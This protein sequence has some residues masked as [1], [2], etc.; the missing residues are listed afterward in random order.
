[1]MVHGTLITALNSQS[2][3]DH[4][5][6]D[7]RFRPLMENAKKL[8]LRS[9]QNRVLYVM[10]PGHY[11]IIVECCVM[12]NSCEGSDVD[13]DHP[14]PFNIFPIIFKTRLCALMVV[15][16][17]NFALIFVHPRLSAIDV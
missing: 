16:D 2:L 7:F 1:M 4:R 17:W 15:L 9:V 6:R 8:I 5:I 3:S 11:Q 10:I 12:L 14:Q 13:A